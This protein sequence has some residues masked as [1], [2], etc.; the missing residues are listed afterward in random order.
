STHSNDNAPILPRTRAPL[1]PLQSKRREVDRRR[2]IADDAGYQ[3]ARR[4]SLR[5]AEHSVPGGDDQIRHP[6]AAADDRQSVG[7]RRAQ[8]GPGLD[9]A[10]VGEPARYSGTARAIV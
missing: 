10:E 7:A 2:L 9:A 3:L 6:T 5:H 4:R 8:A 1:E